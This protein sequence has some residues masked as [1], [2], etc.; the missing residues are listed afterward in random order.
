LRRKPESC[1]RSL[2]ARRLAIIKERPENDK[3]QDDPRE[4]PM[5]TIITIVALCCAAIPTVG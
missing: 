2:D 5:K 4:G 3:Q 1:F